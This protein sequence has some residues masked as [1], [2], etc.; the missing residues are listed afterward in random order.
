MA[1]ALPPPPPPRGSLSS[2]DDP[3]LSAAS[4]QQA[5]VPAWAVGAGAV[6]LCAL[7][8]IV[9]STTTARISGLEA[10]LAENEKDTIRL[11]AKFESI[12]RTLMRMDGRLERIET[13]FEGTAA[14]PV[15]RP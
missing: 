14:P 7:A 8:G 3:R 13:H 15:K 1:T 6:L 10:R 4:S 9:W 11:V 2:L 5:S 12:D